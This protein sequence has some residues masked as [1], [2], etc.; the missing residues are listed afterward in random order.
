MLIPREITK[1]IIHWFDK[2]KIIIIKGS[3][4]VGKTTLIKIIIDK[5][6]NEQKNTFYLSVDQELNNPILKT[7]NNLLQYI[8][9][10]FPEINKKN[11]L[12]LFLDEFQYLENAGLFLK[13]LFDKS[14]DYIQIIV[15]GSSSL[16]ITKNAEFLTGRKMEFYLYP[17]N[18]REYLLYKTELHLPENL[19]KLS[20]MK[21]FYNIYKEKISNYLIEYISFG[22]YPEVIITKNREDKLAILKELVRTYIDKDIIAFLR[23]EN[24]NGFNN[25][26]RVLCDQIGNL[27]NKSE[28]SNTINLNSETLNKYLDILEG[29]YLIEFV[30]PYFNNARKILSKMQKVYINDF[31]LRNIVLNRSFN[32]T[33]ITGSERENF[34][35]NVL[36]NNYGKDSI[37]YYRTISKSEIDFILKFEDKII[38]IEVKSI[39]KK[40]NTPKAISFFQE[41][42]SKQKRAPSII[43]TD[44]LLDKSENTYFIPSG[45]L[46]FID[47]KVIV[48]ESSK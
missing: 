47:I 31:G 27:V 14:K 44:N 5:L 12:Y 3:R 38:P 35:Y 22:G 17:V 7:S 9:D 32:E 8:N 11:P 16:E 40:I 41:K 45:L 20:E 1:N 42:Y 43:I 19:T 29:T 18:Y 15:S 23:I 39:T 26:L 33:M 10:Q 37:F 6:K 30:K 2:Q 28:I 36:K 13:T 34:T 4:Q 46:P 21:N 24:I 25:L 48:N